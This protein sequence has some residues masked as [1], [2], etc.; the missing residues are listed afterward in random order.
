M[1][2]KTSEAKRKANRE[3]RHRNK[4][5][6]RI[7]TYRRTTK[8]YLTKHATFFE[9]LDFQRYIF[10]RVNELIDSSEYNTE[11]KK[12]LEKLYREVLDGF[13]RRE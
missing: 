4:E 5:K 10:D 7:A 12:E 13:K 3:Y 6:E 9:L 1:D 11:D 8:G 2:Y